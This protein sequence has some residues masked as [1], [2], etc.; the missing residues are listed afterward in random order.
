MELNTI[1]IIFA[2]LATLMVAAALLA[3]TSRN[4]MRATVYLLFVLFGT[5]GIYFILHYTFLGAVQVTV[6]AG[7]I[8]VLF[9]FAALLIGRGARDL[10]HTSI[11][12]YTA[13]FTASVTGLALTIYLIFTH[14]FPEVKSPTAIVPM[15]LIGKTMMGADK[16]NFVLPFEVVSVLL[17]ACMVG[18][19]LIAR[20]R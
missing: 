16:Y 12:R 17:L 2:G 18:A 8:I 9:V 6:Y 5:A 4:I 7:G 1:T 14:A 19:L 11:L 10:T 15:K 20:K 13:G 3:V